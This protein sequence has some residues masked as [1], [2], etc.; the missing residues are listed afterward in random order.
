MMETINQHQNKFVVAYKYKKKMCALD[1]EKSQ[2][3]HHFVVA[4]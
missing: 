3:S 4:V 1:S 2:I